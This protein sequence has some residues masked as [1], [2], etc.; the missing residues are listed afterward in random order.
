MVSVILLQPELVQELFSKK[1]I[2]SCVIQMQRNSNNKIWF[3]VI[4]MLILSGL[5]LILI[6]D[7]SNVHG[8]GILLVMLGG[9]IFISGAIL[10]LYFLLKPFFKKFFGNRK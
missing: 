1:A 2:E 6:P 10:L 5:C 4:S 7:T 9:L 8:G 3:I